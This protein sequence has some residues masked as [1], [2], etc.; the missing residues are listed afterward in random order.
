[1]GCVQQAV[2]EFDEEVRAPWRPL[3]VQG[4]QATGTAPAVAARH[5]PARPGSSRVGACRP[6]VSTDRRVPGASSG[7]VRPDGGRGRH[8]RP[9]APSA[10]PGGARARVGRRR[11]AVRFTRRA[12][13]L[14]V[15][16]A[17]CGGV[18]AGSL[19]GQLSPGGG[20]PGLRLAG[21]S[22]VVVDPGD[23]LWSIATSVAAGE[24]VR[25]V[26][27]RIQELNGLRSTELVPGQVLL[28]P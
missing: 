22:S 9:G 24:D 19:L 2:Q 6:S 8:T 4:S 15:A 23:T 27:D 16:L 7:P 28:L 12:H 21:A 11:T 3:L 25:V 26:V 5:H 10:S 13:R 18:L 14:A 20:G 1:M 17:L